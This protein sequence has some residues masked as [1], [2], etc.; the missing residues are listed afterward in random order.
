MGKAGGLHK[1][2]RNITKEK[3]FNSA[4]EKIKSMHSCH[5]SKMQYKSKKKY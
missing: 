2:Y 3:T 5:E 4:K 1:G